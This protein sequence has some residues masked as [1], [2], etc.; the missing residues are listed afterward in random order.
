MPL[1]TVITPTYNREKNLKDLYA[2]LCAQTSRHFEWLVVDD[3]STDHTEAL[4]KGL[5]EK[6]D[7][8][9][10]YIRKEN[11]G[12]HTALN[13]GIREIRTPLTFIVDSDDTVLPEGIALIERYYEKYRTEQ[14]LGVL[15]FLKADVHKGV[16]LK[17]P[18]DEFVGSYIAERIRTS[19][20]GDM[21]EVFLTSALKEFPFPEFEGERFLSE[22]VVWIPLGRKYKTAFINLPI[23]RCEYLPDGLTR[24]DKVHKFASP[25]GSMMRGKMLMTKECGLKSRVRGA[26]IY[27]CYRK[28][29]KGIIPDCVKLENG[30]D[31]LLVFLLQPASAL[32]YRKWKKDALADRK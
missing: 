3:G 5:A 6:A 30:V 1:V 12:K 18:R 24:N 28:D 26:I 32:F 19:R 4:I 25:L 20:P 23:Y 16:I 14:N 29:T 15:T 13:V 8:A 7:F 22:D 27:G 21:A 11:G 17:M 10:R 31:K 2:S 9:V